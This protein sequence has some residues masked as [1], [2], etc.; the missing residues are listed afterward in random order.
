MPISIHPASW[1][2][3]QLPCNY[4]LFCIQVILIQKLNN[5]SNITWE[6]RVC[7]LWVSMCCW[8]LSCYYWGRRQG[9][10][11]FGLGSKVSGLP[12]GFRGKESTCQYRRHRRRGFD[13]WVGKSPW[14]RK[15][16]PT[17]VFLPGKSHGQR[18]LVGYSQ[19]MGLQRT[20]H[21]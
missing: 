1:G 8:S 5:I 3:N 11:G 21:D 9:I 15:W 7:M 13:P 19:S 18:S 2:K 10:M 16:Q 17:L 20:G 6:K 4:F 14:R 12:R